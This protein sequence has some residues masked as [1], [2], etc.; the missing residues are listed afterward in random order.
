MAKVKIS[1]QCIDCREVP[2]MTRPRRKYQRCEEC[3][4]SYVLSRLNARRVKREL[5]EFIGGLVQYNNNDGWRVGYLVRIA[6][7]NSGGVSIQPIGARGT[8]PD[9]IA[10]P[11]ANVKPE[12]MQSP[13]CPTV[14]DF[15]RMNEKKKVVVLVAGGR[16]AAAVAAAIPRDLSKVIIHGSEPLQT[17]DGTLVKPG[18]SVSCDGEDMDVVEARAAKRFPEPVQEPGKFTEHEQPAAVNKA[19]HPAFD[20][21]EA[22]RLYQLV[23]RPKMS[24]IVEAVRGPRAAGATGNLVRDALRKAGLYEEPVK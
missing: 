20:P 12:P 3:R 16:M 8:I 4:R 10:V 23:P 5:R 1:G 15:Y 17:F 2:V 7:S 18:V 6:D 14:E 21:T 13:S 22:I 11:F 24:A 19:K 9:V